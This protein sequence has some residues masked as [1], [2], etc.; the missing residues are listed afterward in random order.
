MPLP[1]DTPYAALTLIVAPAILT[2]ASSVLALGTSN[3]FARAVDRQWQLSDLLEANARDARDARAA[4]RPLDREV[5][6]AFS[7]QRFQQTRRSLGN[8]AVAAAT[9]GGDAGEGMA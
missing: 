3:R 7:K 1:S 2:N 9:P 5:E 6:A 8:L 4:G